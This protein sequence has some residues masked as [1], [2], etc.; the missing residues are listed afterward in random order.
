MSV[1]FTLLT[2]RLQR[3]AQ[4]W[5]GDRRGATAV[6]FALVAM[7]FFFLILG[8][9]EV[10]LLFIMST[11]L[12]HA[13]AESSRKVRTGQAQ[14][15]GFTKIE[16]RQEVCGELFNLMR[17]DDKL[18]ID[19]RPIVGFSAAK[20]GSP[21]GEDGEVDDEGFKF[22]PGSANDII[23]VR[24]MYEWELKTPFISAPLATMPG[25]RHLLQAN[26]VFRNEP[27]GE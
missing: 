14:E 2:P 8:L 12:E 19:V 23:A 7:P 21:I 20:F 4:T 16:F 3:S 5:C 11:V 15:N 1:P 18:H 6:E 24:V 22:D 27:F 10:C 17:C 26:A 13:V 25:N 9:L